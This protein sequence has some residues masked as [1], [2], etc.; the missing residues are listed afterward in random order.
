[1]TCHDP[2]RPLVPETTTFVALDLTRA[3]AYAALVNRA[4]VETCGGIRVTPG[5]P[6]LSYLYHKVADAT[7]CSGGRMPAHGMLAIQ[8]TLTAAE[9]ATI[10]TWIVG[11]AKP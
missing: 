1:V 6:A 11:G 8:P 7:V 5:D 2:A 3:G 10:S 4:A 9:I